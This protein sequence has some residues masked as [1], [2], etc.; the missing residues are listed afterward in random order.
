MHIC[1]CN[2]SV[3]DSKPVTLCDQ[4]P[5]RDSK[6]ITTITPCDQDP[7]K[8]LDNQNPDKSSDHSERDKTHIMLDDQ[9]PMK[10]SDNL[11]GKNSCECSEHYC[12]H[13][14]N[15]ECG[16]GRWLVIDDEC[17]SS[18]SGTEEDV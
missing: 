18:S 3:R 5:V 4:D 10:L 9:N 12:D 11:D 8:S 2:A 15:D 17:T 6:P 13:I 1:H 14:H 16:F 7:D